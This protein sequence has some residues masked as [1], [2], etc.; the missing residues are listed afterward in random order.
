MK[1]RF[2]Q[3]LFSFSFIYLGNFTKLSFKDIDFTI[4]VDII[5]NGRFNMKKHNILKVVLLSIVVVAL[6]SWIFP[7]AQFQDVLIERDRMQAGLF[8]LFAYPMVS[9]QYFGSIA[10]YVLVCGV[11]YGVAYRIPAYR[12]LIQRIVDG[13]QGMEQ[14]F[15]GVAIIVIA[16]IVSVSG[17]S[18]PIIFVFPFVIDVVLKMGY[19]RLVAATVTVGSTIAGIAGTTLGVLTTGFM[20]QTL[21]I[22]SFDEMISKVVILVIFVVLLIAQVV[23]Y[24]KKTRNVVEAS[25]DQSSTIEE[26]KSEEEEMKV[27]SKSSKDEKSSSKTSSKRGRKPSS[28][29]ASKE[30]KKSDTKSKSTSKR[31]RP[32][33]NSAAMAK[34]SSEVLVVPTKKEKEANIWP[35]VIIFDLVVFILAISVFDW[36]GL[37]EIT[38]FKDATEAVMT[39]EIGGFPI[40]GKILGELSE[41]GN[42]NISI[43]IPALIMMATCV[44][45]LVYRVKWDTFIEGAYDGFKRAI[46]PAVIMLLTYVVLVVVTYHSF[47][48]SIIKFFLD[49]TS[50]I[51]VVTMTLVG[52]LSSV[53]NI[54]LSYVTQNVVPY[55]QTVITDSKLYPLLGVIF[56]STYALV[57]LIAPTSFILMGTLEYLGISYKQWVKYIW[58]LF[59]CLLAILVVIF[60]IVLA[61]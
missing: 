13:F 57:L 5:N 30:A 58:K 36:F 11:F 15:L 7:G 53:F 38:W 42:W 60:L 31:G 49:L 9:L 37:F 52:L 20:N 32:S 44:L 17:I 25:N 28:D 26:K 47:Q 22:T 1:K 35:L 51:N 19:N 3:S 50:G 40:F 27:V 33:K 55:I 46:R 12:Q 4:N 34:D 23:L 29:K 48:L 41:F 18:V 61:I 24:G 59:L 14:F 8:D 39:Y 10:L 21:Q 16:T 54:E 43:E 45:A 56:Q 6:C 2:F